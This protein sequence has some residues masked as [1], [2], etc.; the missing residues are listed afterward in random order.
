MPSSRPKVS[1]IMPTYNRAHLLP[2]AVRSVLSQTSDDFEL[3]ISNG[4]STDET[5][6][7]VAGFNDPRIRYIESRDRLAID[8]NYQQ[9]LEHATGEYLTFLSDDDAYTP[10]LLERV[11]DVLEETNADVVGYQYCRYYHEDTFDLETRVPQNSLLVAEFDRSLTTFSAGEALEHVMACHA[12]SSTPVDTRF[13]CPYLSN[14][15][16]HRSIYDWRRAKRANLFA[17]V[18][19]DIY[20]EAAVFFLAKSY[21]CLDEPLL[22][23]SN[24]EGNATANAGRPEVRVS[25][26]YKRLLNGREL[27][28]TPLKFALALNCGAN[29]VLEAIH[30]LGNG[31]TTIDWDTYF[32]KTFENFVFLKSLGVDTSR[33]EREF[34]DVLALQPS[35]LRQKVES[36]LGDPK[37]RVKALLN[38]RTPRVAAFLRKAI[39]SRKQARLKLIRGSVSGFS[40][41]V[42]AASYVE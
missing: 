2:F 5:R 19:A 37:F 33:E 16:Y 12:L 21:V 25:E 14:A 42:E 31:E 13:I 8:R 28:H 36:Q 38:S 29:A 11:R 40:N 20:L 15:T 9:G 7:V 23:W 35:D 39:G 41:V 17:M 34:W 24:W 6:D 18:T 30:E 4:G 26:H 27:T 32:A 3:V 22:V 1:V 10:N